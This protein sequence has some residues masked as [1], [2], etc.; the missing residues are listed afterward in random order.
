MDSHPM[1]GK[2]GSDGG[3]RGY[4]ATRPPKGAGESETE[5]RG[6]AMADKSMEEEIDALET[7]SG[8]MT[9]DRPEEPP[10]EDPKDE[11]K[12]EEVPPEAKP[13]EPPAEEPVGDGGD[14][15]K[16]KVPEDKPGTPDGQPEERPDKPKDDRN[17]FGKDGHTPKGVQQRFSEF[18]RQV[19]GLKEENASLRA[20]IEELKKSRPKEQP[21]GRDQFAT[22]EEWVNHVAGIKAAEIVAQK[23]AEA[24][25]RE[26][27]KSAERE[28][29]KSEEAART[30]FQDYDDVMS[31]EVNLPVDRDT[32][33]Y[34]MRSPKGAEI[35]Y[36]LRK[37][38]A[39][40]NGFLAAPNEGKLAFIKGIE[41]RLYQIEKQQKEQPPAK[42]QDVPPAQPPK[43]TQPTPNIRQPQSPRAVP[44]R[45]PD[46]ATCSMDE[47]MEYG[48]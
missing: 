42:P 36:T 43:E 46:P 31:S 16:D 48:D 45:R 15:D 27:I 19:R 17:D 34:V 10:K 39:V 11:P 20:E 26:E 24:S 3:H 32:Y 37:I 28:F 6:I 30:K 12:K 41:Q 1:A 40:R 22:D 14:Q 29:E 13:E 8:K 33:M 4:P 21:K 47:W 44:S 35:Q 5:I 18:S 2:D 38:E 23:M 7:F 9:E 25:E